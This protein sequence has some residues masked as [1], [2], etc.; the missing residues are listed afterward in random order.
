MILASVGSSKVGNKM[1][2]MDIKYNYL[3]TILSIINSTLVLKVSFKELKIDVPIK[4]DMY[5]IFVELCKCNI[6]NVDNLI[7]VLVKNNIA[8]IEKKHIFSEI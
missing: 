2:N 4:D 6:L 3:Y 7:K 5:N 8:D 1:S